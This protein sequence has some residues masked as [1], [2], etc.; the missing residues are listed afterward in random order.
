MHEYCRNWW[1]QTNNMLPL[2]RYVNCTLKIYQSEDVDIVF[3]YN[4][5]PPLY[6]TQLTYPSMQPS[7]LML[8]KNSLLIP[9]KK[10][11]QLKRIP[12]I[13][14]TPTKFNAKQMVLSTRP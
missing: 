9:S 13:K 6:S 11:T 3:R 4:T 12:K 1:T 2:V 5:H 8:L 7:M 10:H 14:N